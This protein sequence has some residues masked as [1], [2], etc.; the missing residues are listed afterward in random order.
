M[1]LQDLGRSTISRTQSVGSGGSIFGEGDPPP[2]PPALVVELLLPTASL[3]GSV[4]FWFGWLWVERVHWVTVGDGQPQFW[5]SSWRVTYI[6][7]QTCL[8][9]RSLWSRISRSTSSS[10]KFPLFIFGLRQFNHLSLQLFR[11]LFNPTCRNKPS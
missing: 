1:F 6:C 3:L 9:P 8:L 7:W 2:D 5:V 10:A 11:H 4:R